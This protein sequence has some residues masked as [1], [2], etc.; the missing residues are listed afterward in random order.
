MAA[1]IARYKKTFTGNFPVCMVS[2]ITKEQIFYG[3]FRISIRIQTHRRPAESHRLAG[4][5]ISGRKPVRNSSGS[6]RFRQDLHH[7]QRHPAVK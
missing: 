2:K 5:G 1:D 6:H 3:S 4:K 7:G